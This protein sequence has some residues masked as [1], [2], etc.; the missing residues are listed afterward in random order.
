MPELKKDTEAS[1]DKAFHWTILIKGADG[2]LEIIGGLFLLVVSG[3]TIASWLRALTQ[4]ELSQDPN[5]FVSNHILGLTQ[6]IHSS[7]V[8][9]AIYLLSHG[10][11][12]VVLVA[13]L[14]KNRLWA[15]PATIA[16]LLLFIVY[17]AY[18]IGFDRS[19]GLIFLTFFDAVIVWLT[20]HEYQKQLKLRESKKTS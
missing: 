8:F 6:H 4:H 14:L 17:Q 19:I 11:I 13:A 9:G 10:I 7:Q 2:L 12:K 1:I 5:D 18:R 15:Y 3:D 16:F 20:W